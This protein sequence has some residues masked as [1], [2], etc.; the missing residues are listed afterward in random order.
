[1]AEQDAVAEL[2]AARAAITAYCHGDF[3]CRSFFSCDSGCPFDPFCNTP[4]EAEQA[5]SAT[6]GDAT[7]P[8]GPRAGGEAGKAE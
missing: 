8:D 7:E 3:E 5:P 4:R 6:R 2:A 1:M